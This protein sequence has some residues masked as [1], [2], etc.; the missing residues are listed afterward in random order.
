[1]SADDEQLVLWLCMK[2]A[3]IME[4]TLSIIRPPFD[5]QEDALIAVEALERR[6]DAIAKLAAAAVALSEN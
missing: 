2:A 5:C 1:M 3:A 6:A 4:D